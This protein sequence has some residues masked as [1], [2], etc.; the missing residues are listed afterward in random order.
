VILG[1]I[2][3]SEIRKRGEEDVGSLPAIFKPS[4]AAL[5]AIAAGVIMTVIDIAV[6]IFVIRMIS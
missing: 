2:A 4:N 5:V 6:V 1:F 3:R